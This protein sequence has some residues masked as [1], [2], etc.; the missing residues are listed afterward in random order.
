ML[1]PTHDVTNSG[2]R[3][4]SGHLYHLYNDAVRADLCRLLS[5]GE[6][7]SQRPRLQPRERG[8]LTYWEL[9]PIPTDD[10]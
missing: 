4:L 3:S 1:P 9:A 7:A 8:G 5:T 10:T 6:P 2:G